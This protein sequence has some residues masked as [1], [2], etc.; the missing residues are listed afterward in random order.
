M[1]V[2]VQLMKMMPPSDHVCIWCK[3]HQWMSQYVIK[4]CH[5]V[6]KLITNSSST[7]EINFELAERIIQVI[8]SMPWVRCASGIV[9]CFYRTQVYL[10]SDLWVWIW[11]IFVKLNWSDSGWWGYQVNTIWGHSEWN[12]LETFEDALSKREKFQHGKLKN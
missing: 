8:E 7:T 10:G 1:Q 9:F 4:C 11:V 2:V 12:K 3:Y 6:A 5:L